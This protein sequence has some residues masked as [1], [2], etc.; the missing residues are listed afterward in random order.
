MHSFQKNV[1]DVSNKLNAAECISKNWLPPNDANR[2]PELLD[3]LRV[4]RKI[5]NFIIM[6]IFLMSLEIL[7]VLIKK[8]TYL[9]YKEFNAKCLK[10]LMS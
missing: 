2:V 1:D 8:V 7:A 10:M 6:L 9:F 3:E 5:M 4:S